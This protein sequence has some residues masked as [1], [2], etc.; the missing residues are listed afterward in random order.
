METINNMIKANPKA[1]ELKQFTQL[2]NNAGGDV[3]K[4]FYSLCLAKGVDP[5]YILGLLK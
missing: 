3:N 5:N 1:Q 2:V 4:A